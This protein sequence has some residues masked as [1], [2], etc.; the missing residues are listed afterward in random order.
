MV[1]NN[2]SRDSVFSLFLT[3]CL[4]G[5]SIFFVSNRDI[6]KTVFVIEKG[7]SLNT[8]TNLLYEKDIIHN[9]S[10]F[11]YRVYFLGL[12]NKIPVGTFVVEGKVSSRNII[13]TIFKDGPIRLKLTIPEG[14]SSEQIFLN[15]NIL[16]D[17]SDDYNVLFKDLTF[18]KEFNIQASSL[19]GYLFPDTY[20]F[21]E[22][23]SGRK[24]LVTMIDEFWKNFN[25]T[26]I[27]RTNELGFTVHEVVTLA[28]I[29]EGEALLNKERAIISSVYHN[30]L[31]KRMKL[32]ADP[33]I[34]YLI[35]GNPKALSIRD[36]RRVSPYNTYLNYGLPPG[37][38]NNPGL[39]SIRAALYPASTDY[40]YFV[41]QGDG[42]HVFTT[43]QQ[44]HLKAKKLYK[45]YK[46]ENR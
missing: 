26:F 14:S 43:N 24:V 7:M 11:K 9:K 44:D 29:I 22:G 19:E 33:T 36:L 12:S 23:T 34:Q 46:R 38:I 13:N 10:F 6:D 31:K 39:E 40:L 1:A 2:N 32:Q 45:Q 16:F 35:P 18:M 17:A 28:S 21:F 30:R 3:V 37:P 4:L 42:S 25:K 41:A 5:A 20:Y 27:E 8:V 15:A